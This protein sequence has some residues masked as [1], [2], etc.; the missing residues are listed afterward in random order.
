MDAE[1]AG[2][3]EVAGFGKVL[4]QRPVEVLIAA[5]L[6][7]RVDVIVRPNRHR[8]PVRRLIPTRRHASE[9]LTPSRISR[10]NW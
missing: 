3:A 9:L 5:A 2:Y 1:V 4:T 10:A 8:V 6:P 7:R